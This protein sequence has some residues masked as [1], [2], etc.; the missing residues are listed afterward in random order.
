MERSGKPAERDSWLADIFGR[1]EV[2]S[3]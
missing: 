3:G 1:A 2:T